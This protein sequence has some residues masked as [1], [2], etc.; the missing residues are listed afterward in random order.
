[1]EQTV[2]KKPIGIDEMAAFCKRKGLVYPTSEIYGSLAGFWDLGP[3]GVDFANNLKREWWRYH[4]HERDDIAGMDGSIIT[5][6][7]VWEASGHVECF[8]DLMLTCTKCGEKIR[9]DHYIEE[10][11]QISAAGFKAEQIND[12]VKTHKLVCPKCK[13]QFDE[14]KDFNLLFETNVGPIVTPTSKSYL[15]GET[16]QSIFPAYKLVFENAR[17]QLPAGIAQIGKAFRNEISPRNFLFRCREFEMM[18]LEFFIH[19]DKANECPYLDEVRDH[20]MFFYTA[21]AQNE[22]ASAVKMKMGDAIDKKI[23][24]TS[25]HA[26]WLAKEH[27]WFVRLG[28]NPDKFRIRQHLSDEKS[29]YA[30]D[31]WDLEFEFPFGYK[32]LL[33]MANRGNFDVSRHMQYSKRDLSMFDE[34]SKSRVVPHVVAEP[35]LGV[36]RAMLVFLFD[37]YEDDATRQN[38]VLHLHPRLSP[39][40]AAILPLINKEQLPEIAEKLYRQLRSI[41]PVVYD[42][43]G[44]IGKRYARNDEM[45]TPLCFTV[46]FDTLK[47]NSVTVRDRDSTTQIRVA[48]EDVEEL[49]YNFLQKD[50]NFEKIKEKYAK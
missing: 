20:E 19:P 28:A 45:G 17:L 43:G 46:D 11:V 41:Y 47:D 16:A 14:A 23:I 33:G 1:M 9:A 32:E 37:A 7:K 39:V 15:R 2:E 38:V 49:L 44:S 4:V 25:W 24:S 12:V 3:L 31:T 30:S 6:P 26:Y 22:N 10:K 5:H 21:K 29:H 18:E 40:K 35:S 36:G 42:T 34:A 13:G 27:Q 8:G 50:W 48:I